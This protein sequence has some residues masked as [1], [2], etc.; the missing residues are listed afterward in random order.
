MQINV[1]EHISEQQHSDE[2][3]LGKLKLEVKLLI[4]YLSLRSDEQ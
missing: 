3:K 1:S 2:M 4:L